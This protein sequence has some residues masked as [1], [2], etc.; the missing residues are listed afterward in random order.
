[1]KLIIAVMFALGLLVISISV[2]D[3]IK[4]KSNKS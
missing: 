3:F 2:I 4:S 1:M